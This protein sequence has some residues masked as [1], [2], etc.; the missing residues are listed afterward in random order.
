MPLPSRVPTHSRLQIS[1]RARKQLERDPELGPVAERS[2]EFMG[3]IIR[4]HRFETF[5]EANCF[6]THSFH[7]FAMD[8]I[9]LRMRIH[10]ISALGAAN[11]PLRGLGGKHR[12]AGSLNSERSCK[13]CPASSRFEDIVAGVCRISSPHR[14]LKSMPRLRSRRLRLRE[15]R[16]RAGRLRGAPR[17]P[18]R[19]AAAA[20]ADTE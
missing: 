5:Q 11:G 13:N 6:E 16:A 7:G 1:E 4:A 19:G 14:T 9:D 17:E 2:A 8:L 18:P 3:F 12:G 20:V 10:E 15:V